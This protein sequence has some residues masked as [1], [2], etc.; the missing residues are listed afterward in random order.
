MCKYLYIDLFDFICLYIHICI[1]V[2]SI[3][4]IVYLLYLFVQ[5]SF[6]LTNLFE[7]ILSYLIYVHGCGSKLPL[8][9][10]AMFWTD[11][12]MAGLQTFRE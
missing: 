6:Y 1:I 12:R 9:R 11:G 5:V 3:D 7:P 8:D 4:L 10:S 2:P